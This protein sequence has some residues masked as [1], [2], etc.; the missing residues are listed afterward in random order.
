MILPISWG[1]VIA[2]MNKSVIDDIPQLETNLPVLPNRPDSIQNAT[3]HIT[4]QSTYIKIPGS[5]SNSTAKYTLVDKYL[6]HYATLTN[7]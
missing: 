1:D 5:F 7:I 4:L 3:N 2:Q 6:L